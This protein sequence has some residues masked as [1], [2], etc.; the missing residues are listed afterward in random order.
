[1]HEA[2]AFAKKAYVEELKR[3]SPRSWLL[4]RDAAELKAT[5]RPA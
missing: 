3:T 2:D 5:R 1:M 4:K